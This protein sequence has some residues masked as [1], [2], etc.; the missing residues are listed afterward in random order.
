MRAARSW[1]KAPTRTSPA[2]SA[3]AIAYMGTRRM[4]DGARCSQIRDLHAW[5]GE[6]HVLHGVDLDVDQGRDGDP[7][8]PQRCRQD[9]HPARDHGASR[10][11]APARSR[12]TARTL[13]RAAAASHRA[14]RHRLCA[15]GARHLRQ[16]RRR[17]RIC[18]CR[19]WWRDGG[20]SARGDLSPV[21]RTCRNGARARARKLSGGEQQMLA[22]ARMLR[23]GAEAA[24]AR[25]TDG[26]PGAGHR[27]SDRRRADR[28]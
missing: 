16:P 4:A 3:C 5:Y 9:H 24:A 23:T 27:R 14:C 11:S 19:R 21:S 25:R 28:R 8:R 15:G 18:C 26:R 10:A 7:P 6:S 12:S 13:M 20:M 17:R 1:P 2:T 22:I